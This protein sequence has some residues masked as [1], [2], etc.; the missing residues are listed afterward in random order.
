[1]SMQE[2]EDHLVACDTCR[3]DVA[4][5]RQAATEL[6]V[7]ASGAGPNT[8]RCLDE[9]AVVELVDGTVDPDR[10]ASML[11][12]LASCPTCRSEVAALSRLTAEPAIRGE[13]EAIDSTTLG[14]NRRRFARVGGTIGFAAVAAAVA[15]LIVARS[16]QVEDPATAEH[17][18]PVLTL[19]APPETIAPVGAA[20]MPIRFVWTS[21]PRADRYA[22]TLFDRAGSTLWEFQT[23]DTVAVTPDSV[24]LSSGLSYFWKVEARTDFDRWSESGLVEFTPASRPRGVR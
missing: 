6:R 7:H 5:I 24:A 13:L 11:V 16:P 12:H 3:E 18:A 21:V 17:R 9:F 22:L 10:R 19:S 15:F 20:E 1:M 2:L 23:P 14:T 4:T 8:D